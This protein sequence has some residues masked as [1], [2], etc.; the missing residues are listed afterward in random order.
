MSHIPS[1]VVILSGG[2]D[3]AV[4]LALAVSE[5][6]PQETAAIS[7]RYGQRH[8]RELLS[9]AAL[10]KHYRVPQVVID[11]GDLLVGSDALTSTKP[12]PTD[13]YDQ[14]SMSDTVVHGRNLLFA[15]VALA[16]AQ[17]LDTLWTG[18]HGGDHFI[19]PDC[20]PEFWQGFAQTADAYGIEVRTPFIRS[21]KADIVRTGRELGVPFELTWSCYK[22]NEA[23][24]G[25][26]G[27]CRERAEAFDKAGIVDV[28]KRLV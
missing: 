15:S 17:P 12:V 8:S 16:H 3:S 25:E 28:T 22:G 7:F 10:V 13:P 5:S 1:N 6:S 9:A 14:A 20:R 26:C 23:P 21:S 2:V 4:T 18:V 19:Y 11:L 27:T 24:C